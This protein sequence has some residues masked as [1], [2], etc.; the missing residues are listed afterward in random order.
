MRWHCAVSEAGEGQV[1]RVKR[2]G[3]GGSGAT[4]GHG[5]TCLNR[6]ETRER[7][8]ERTVG[9]VRVHIYI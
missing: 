4:A 7:R 2:R 6:N 5:D 8:A 1:R 3:V 9:V